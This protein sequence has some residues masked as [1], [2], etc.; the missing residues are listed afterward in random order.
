MIV[1]TKVKIVMDDDFHADHAGRLIDLGL[2]N[3]DEHGLYS[4]QVLS[5]VVIE[6]DFGIAE[7]GD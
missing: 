2:S 7:A 3:L 6:D 5:N 1:Y 4:W